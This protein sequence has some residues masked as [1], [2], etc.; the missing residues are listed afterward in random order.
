MKD[1]GM[2]DFT[3][4]PAVVNGV[5]GVPKGDDAI[6]LII[7]ARP[8]NLVFIDPPKVDLP[9]PDLVARLA[10]PPGETLYVAKVDLD[11]FYHRLL[12]PEWMRPY[13]A[14]PAIRA[15][16]VGLVEEFG[17]DVEMFPCCKTLP[18]GWS[19]SVFVAQRSHEYFLDTS[20]GL[21]PQDR[22]TLS[23]DFAVDRDRHQVYIDDV[24]LFG[25]N[26]DRLG[27]NKPSIS[28]R[29]SASC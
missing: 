2:V 25:L 16:D 9:T 14:L 10:V 23:N 1:L 19:H 28:R 3:T 26:K 15:S 8:A 24:N 21:R 5:F 6:R 20:T 13:F 29:S 17:G 18:M 22:I 7:D 12:L 27:R 11:N 4:K